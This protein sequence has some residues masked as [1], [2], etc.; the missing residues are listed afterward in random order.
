MGNQTSTPEASG[1]EVSPANPGGDENPEG[2]EVGFRVVR[3]MEGSPGAAA[4]LESYFDFIV[5]ANGTP[6]NH[7][8][9][10]FVS[11]IEEFEDK[12]LKLEVWNRR[13]H[14]MRNVILQPNKSWGGPS[15]L[16]CNVRFDAL[17]ENRDHVWHVLDVYANSPASRAGLE[18][19]TDYIVGTPEFLFKN[20]DDLF[21]LVKN[22]MG[23]AIKMFVYST[24]TET[25]REVEVT[26]DA[27]WG[28]SGSLGCDVGSGYL[29]RIPTERKEHR[30]FNSENQN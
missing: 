18:P 29:H 13:T 19:F 11:L 14:T 25:V 7:E 20:E 21:Q 2:H 8:D 12:E 23:S 27:T 10:V 28:G 4:G 26:P 9:T 17:A 1:S 16:G 3:V 6:L 5:T 22:N 30:L 15:L 24:R